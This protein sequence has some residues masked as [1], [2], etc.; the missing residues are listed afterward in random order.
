MTQPKA[1]TR[2]D[3][4]LLR[5]LPERVSW[6]EL[7]P[8]FYR[9]WGFPGGHWM[10]EHL[11]IY[12]PTGSGKS[13]FE[14]KVLI[15]RHR[16]HG[17]HVVV[18]ATKPADKTLMSTGWPI[19]TEWPPRKGWNDKRQFECVIFWAKSGL[20][21]EAQDRQAYQIED[22]LH[23]LWVPDSNIIVA[24]DEII[25]LEQELGLKTTCSTYFREG[26]TVGITV[27]AG[28]QRPANVNRFMHSE[29]TWS[30]YFAPKDEDDAKRMAEV[31]GNREYYMRILP[32]LDRARHEFLLVN[33]VT[34]EGFI[35]SMPTSGRVAVPPLPQSPHSDYQPPT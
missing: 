31:A 22:L 25:Y 17:D 24:F 20:G 11:T 32:E 34:R 26:R 18:I 9:A 35:T 29:A 5:A 1:V 2:R 28:T 10:P 14:S 27:V 21:Q 8:D 23:Q 19:I 12:G 13:F 3:T 7:G 16:L 6:E 33:S 4:A 15:E 30:A